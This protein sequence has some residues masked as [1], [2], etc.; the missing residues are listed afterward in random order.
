[1][2][3]EIYKFSKITVVPSLV[4]LFLV[5]CNGHMVTVAK[6]PEK[7]GIVQ[8]ITVNAPKTLMAAGRINKANIFALEAA[9]LATIK[10]S[11]YYF[12]IDLPNGMVSNTHGSLINTAKDYIKTC[13]TN[14]F[15]KDLGVG[16]LTL[17]LFM[18]YSHDNC[19][20]SNN[21][22]SGQLTIISYKEQ[23]LNFTS[24]DAKDVIRYLKKDKLFVEVPKGEYIEQLVKK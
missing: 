7:T 14:S 17:G 12:S 19:H 10:N 16:L 23:P 18:N 3:K 1:M 6:L 20:I 21:T 5:G 15:A 4:V 2:L 13:N 9:A 8:A 11:C 22:G 24:Y